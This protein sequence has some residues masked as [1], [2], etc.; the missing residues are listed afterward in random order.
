MNNPRISVFTVNPDKSCI[1]SYL[2]SHIEHSFIQCC[3]AATFFYDSGS[4]AAQLEV[5]ALAPS[6]SSIE[7][8]NIEKKRLYNSAA[9]H[10]FLVYLLK[11]SSQINF[12]I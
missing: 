10:L 8:K 5:P 3:G 6:T 11:A 1:K 9:K 12:L 4:G 7:R 2:F